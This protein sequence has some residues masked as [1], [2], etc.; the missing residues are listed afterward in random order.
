MSN[1]SNRY[2]ISEM[3]GILLMLIGVSLGLCIT[4]LSTHQASTGIRNFQSMWAGEIGM[5]EIKGQFS[6]VYQPLNESVRLAKFTNTGVYIYLPGLC[7]FVVARRRRWNKALQENT[8]HTEQG[9]A[10]YPPQGVGSP[11]R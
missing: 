5:A 11:E 4:Y 3:L 2:S 7:L 8:K 1:K 9:V 6:E 10:G